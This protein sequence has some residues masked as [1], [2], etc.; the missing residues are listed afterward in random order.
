MKFT[1]IE[2]DGKVAYTDGERKLI[3]PSKDAL[4]ERLIKLLEDAKG[5]TQSSVI[6]GFWKDRCRDTGSADDMTRAWGGETYTR[7]WEIWDELT[8]PPATP[9]EDRSSIYE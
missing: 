6:V 8:T 5:D 9:T 2:K 7:L 3:V 1:R 4:R